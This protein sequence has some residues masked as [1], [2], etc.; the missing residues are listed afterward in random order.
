MAFL[1]RLKGGQQARHLP[2]VVASFIHVDAAVDAIR[3]LRAKGYRDL[4]VYPPRQI[5]MRG[6]SMGEYGPFL[7]HLRLTGCTAGFGMT[8]WMYVALDRWGSDRVDSALRRHR[9]ECHLMG[10]S[11][12]WLPSLFSCSGANGELRTTALQRDMIGYS[13]HPHDPL[14]HRAAPHRPGV[15]VAMRGRGPPASGCVGRARGV[16]VHHSCDFY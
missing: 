3:A 9:F 13:C 2:G 10:L 14:V 11:A 6:R 15:E 5:T 7:R 1:K 8:I 12:R 16:P 4:V